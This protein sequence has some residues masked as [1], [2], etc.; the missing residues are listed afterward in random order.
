MLS[1]QIISSFFFAV[2][3]NLC[4]KTHFQ[5]K[6]HYFTFEELFGRHELV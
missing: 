1:L 3:L 2:S 6:R 5:A 4:K